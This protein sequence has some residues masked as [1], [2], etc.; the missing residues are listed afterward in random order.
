MGV[1]GR[2]GFV[3]GRFGW[4]CRAGRAAWARRRMECWVAGECGTREVVM[5]EC[6]TREV[7]MTNSACGQKERPHLW[8]LLR[9]WPPGIRL[10]VIRL[11]PLVVV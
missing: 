6:G 4:R 3:V 10:G 7:V 8:E 9:H 2:L 1:G 11:L 5:C